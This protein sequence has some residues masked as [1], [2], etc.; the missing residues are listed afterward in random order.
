MLGDDADMAEL[1]ERD[2]LEALHAELGT[3]P[4][5]YYRNLHLWTTAFVAGSVA[6][7]ETDDCVS[8]SRRSSRSTADPRDATTTTTATSSRSRR[9]SRATAARSAT[10]TTNNYGDF[11]VDRLEAGEDYVVT[12]HAEGYETATVPVTLDTSRTLATV[13][14]Q[15]V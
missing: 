14:L 11:V 15:K 7:K 2:E 5:V 9:S 12:F 13:F 10:P 6:D 3:R 1:V 4:R 8:A